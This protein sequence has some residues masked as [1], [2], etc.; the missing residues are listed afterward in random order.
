MSDFLN[1]TMAKVEADAA[2][3][4]YN[5]AG[6]KLDNA[7]IKERLSEIKSQSEPME[8]LLNQ[9][10]SERDR[11]YNIAFYVVVGRMPNEVKEC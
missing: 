11:L 3:Q 8:S 1:Y 9:A 5:Y 7:R 10:L 2:Y 6:Q 4:L